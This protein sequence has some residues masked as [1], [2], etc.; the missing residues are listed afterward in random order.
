VKYVPGTFIPLANRENDYLMDRSTQKS[1][2][3]YS[4]IE[5][6]AMQDASLQES[7]GPVQ[8]RTKENLCSTDNGIIMAR[9]LLLRAG[10]AN[11]EGKPLPGL[12][13]ASQRV[14]SCAI[15]LPRNVHFRDGAWEGLFRELDTDPVTV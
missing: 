10:Q 14:R 2:V 1:G 4:G 15:E 8:D 11:R 12:A 6:I 13:P 5:G 9:R 3:N 7:M